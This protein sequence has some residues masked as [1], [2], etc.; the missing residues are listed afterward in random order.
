MRP[1]HRARCVP[2]QASRGA[3]H[4][5]ATHHAVVR[6][7]AVTHGHSPSSGPGINPRRAGPPITPYRSSKLVI[8]VIRRTG[9]LAAGGLSSG[10]HEQLAFFGVALLEAPYQD[11]DEVGAASS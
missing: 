2:E 4:T 11:A 7:A 6:S 3:G 1:A 9:R 5:R 8:F 10:A